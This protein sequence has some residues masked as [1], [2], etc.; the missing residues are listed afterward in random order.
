[1][2]PSKEGYTKSHRARLTLFRYC[3]GSRKLSTKNR[4]RFKYRKNVGD[5][6]KIQKYNTVELYRTDAA[7][8]E[9]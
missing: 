2:Y 3:C 9:V 5:R 4:S 6:S 8:M 7:G 1:M